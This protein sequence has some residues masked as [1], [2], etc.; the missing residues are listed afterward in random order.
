MSIIKQTKKIMQNAILN[1]AEK[2]KVENKDSQVLIY[3]SNA[4][5]E[6]KYM[7]CTK[8]KPLN[9]VSFNELLNVKVDF[10]GREFIA[11][12]FI[13]NTFNRIIKEQKC[14]DFKD[15]NV[16]VYSASN[17]VKE[18]DI[19]IHLFVGMKPIKEVTFDYLLGE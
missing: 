14:K 6:P 16:I 5:L 2:N 19:K 12:S 18:T 13:R 8:W 11:G 7:V 4:D 10:L 3:P 9:E 17:N 1:F 15:V